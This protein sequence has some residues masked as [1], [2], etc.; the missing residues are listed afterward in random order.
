MTYQ[1]AIYS[2][3]LFV[4]LQT[5]LGSTDNLSGSSGS[6]RRKKKREAELNKEREMDE[7]D[8]ASLDWWSKYYASIAKQEVSIPYSAL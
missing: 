5:K 7:I 2:D 6:V 8:W 3:P 1:C 4:F